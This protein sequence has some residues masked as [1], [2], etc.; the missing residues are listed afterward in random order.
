L[1]YG[2]NA[3]FDIKSPVKIFHG[4]TKKGGAS[5]RGPPP[6]YAIDYYNYCCCCCSFPWKPRLAV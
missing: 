3:P 4:R 5:H 2:N 1:E 6:K